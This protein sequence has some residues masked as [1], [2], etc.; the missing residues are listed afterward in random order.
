MYTISLAGYLKILT[1]NQIFG[2]GWLYLYSFICLSAG[3]VE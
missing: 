2:G 3:V 1:L